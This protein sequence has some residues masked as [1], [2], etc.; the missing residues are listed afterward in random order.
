MK[1]LVWIILSVITVMSA[2]YLVL[3]SV[4]MAR[5]AYRYRKN[6]TL[7]N[8]VELSDLLYLLILLV[9]CIISYIFLIIIIN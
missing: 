7:F 3:L 1:T 2:Y 4:I 5:A 9:I 8:K 6:P